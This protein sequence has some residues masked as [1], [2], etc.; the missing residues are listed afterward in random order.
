MKL[1]LLYEDDFLG[2]VLKPPCIH[3]VSS[4]EDSLSSLLTSKSSLSE[5]GLIQRLDFET[6]G[7]CLFAKTIKSFEFL[8]DEIKNHRIEKE[9]VAKIDGEAPRDLFLEGYLGSRYR[10]SKKVTISKTSQKRFLYFSMNIKRKDFQ[11][12]LVNTNYGRRHQVRAGLSF[13]GFPL[14]GDSLYEGSKSEEPFYLLASKIKFTHPESSKSIIIDS[15][16]NL[17]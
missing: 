14:T 5:S 2:V 10:G 7:V 16:G 4:K 12:V 15:D 11:H 9:Y 13:L 3:T 1:R 17:Y 8:K 6:Q